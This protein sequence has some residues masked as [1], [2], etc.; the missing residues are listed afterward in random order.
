MYCIHCI[1]LWCLETQHCWP[2]CNIVYRIAC[3]A[4][5]RTVCYIVCIVSNYGTRKF[6]SIGLFV[7]L[8]T[9]YCIIL[10]HLKIH[11]WL[12][13][14]NTVH[15]IVLYCIVLWYPK[16]ISISHYVILSTVMHAVYYI[17][18]PGHLKI[19]LFTVLHVLHC[20]VLRLSYSLRN[21][22]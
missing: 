11:Q 19:I 17:V 2:F 5:Y 21:M 8:A 7:I 16:C 6:I 18:V 4:L 1:V 10:W 12:P 9:V 3:I 13:F 22:L 20:I 14:C 15:F